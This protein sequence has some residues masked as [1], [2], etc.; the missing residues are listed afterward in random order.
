[1]EWRRISDAPYRAIPEVVS[2]NAA[3]GDLRISY[4]IMR[5]LA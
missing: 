2:P 4:E 3:V 5:K 1:V